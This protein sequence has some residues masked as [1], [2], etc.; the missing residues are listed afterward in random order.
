MLYTV[1]TL[2]CMA[3]LCRAI[4]SSVQKLTG[5]DLCCLYIGLS[6]VGD[7]WRSTG[8]GKKS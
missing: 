5:R 7:T 3:V 4:Q 1:S 2:L 8:A 6:P